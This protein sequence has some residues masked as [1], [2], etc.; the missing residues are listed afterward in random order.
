MFTLMSSKKL[1]R[2][3]FLKNNVKFKKAGVL[4]VENSH[5][6]DKKYIDMYLRN[7]IAVAANNL[8]PKN[9][10]DAKVL[11]GMPSGA[12]LS[13]VITR[14]S[15]KISE[16]TIALINYFCYSENEVNL[17]QF[18]GVDKIKVPTFVV[19]WVRMISTCNR[20]VEYPYSQDL[21][22]VPVNKNDIVIRGVSLDSIQFKDIIDVTSCVLELN[23]LCRSVNLD[24]CPEI[25]LKDLYKISEKA[26][27]VSVIRGKEGIVVYQGY[28]NDPEDEYFSMI[29]QPRHRFIDKDIMEFE[30]W[31]FT[32]SEF[33]ESL[34]LF[35]GN[36]DLNE[37][38]MMESY[39]NMVNIKDVGIMKRELA[40]RLVINSRYET[41]EDGSDRVSEIELEKVDDC[42]RRK[43]DIKTP[44]VK[45]EDKSNILKEYK[46][47]G[48]R[49]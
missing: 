28:G 22:V 45:S 38:P 10:K 39:N 42:D 13:T 48:K 21:I 11:L 7:K 9:I 44:V 4:K 6:L 26:Y 49:N 34:A 1:V 40:N 30:E 8:T 2:K 36:I 35:A 33:D 23:Q 29:I 18:I 27:N 14:V 5:T 32:E 15:N 46:G 37:L 20:P 3:S 43:V 31:N 16:N 25:E 17:K 24:E 47:F 12:T 41:V 19:E